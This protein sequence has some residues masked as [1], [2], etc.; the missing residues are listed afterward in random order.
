MWNA[1]T[2]R[3][4]QHPKN[5]WISGQP[6]SFSENDL[7]V[8]CGIYV[9]IFLGLSYKG[10]PFHSGL[11]HQEITFLWCPHITGL[12]YKEIQFPLISTYHRSVI[13]TDSLIPT[14]DWSIIP[15]RDPYSY[16]IQI[17]QFLSDTH[18]WLIYHTLK[19]F[20]F[21]YHTKISPFLWYPHMI[22]VLYLKEIQFHISYK[23]IHFPLIPTYHHDHYWSVSHIHQV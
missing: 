9:I 11:E 17:D 2:T 1:L 6:S 16:L 7:H 23:D 19:R 13:P 12:S 3:P 15:E 18:I 21:I 20:I 14:Y 8:H 4:Y 22:G 10:V 5:E